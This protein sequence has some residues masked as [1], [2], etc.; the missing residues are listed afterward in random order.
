MAKKKHVPELKVLFDTSVLF[1]QAASDL[2]KPE[3]SQLI[4][5]HSSY[6]DHKISWHL[7]DI[8]RHERR[9]QMLK[10][11]K[12]LLPSLRK[13]EKLLGHNLAIS[14]EILEQRVDAAISAQLDSLKLNIVAINPNNVDWDK[15]MLSAVYRRPPFDPGEREKGFRDALVIESFSQLIATSPVTPTVCRVVLVT[16]DKLLTEAANSAATGS[17]NVRI[18]DTLEELKGF[19]NTLV[20]QVGEEFVAELQKKAQPYFFTQKDKTTLYFKEELSKQIKE[21]YAAELAY[22]PDNVT[23]TEADTWYIGNPSFNKKE[24]QRIFWTS[25]IEPTFKCFITEAKQAFPA[26]TGLIDAGTTTYNSIT[27]LFSLLPEKKA[28]GTF[29]VIFEIDWSVNY[30]PNKKFT[31][32]RIE[33]IRYIETKP[34]AG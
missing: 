8:A 20:S 15:V 11:A 7:P 14:E 33:G 10:A 23:D 19:I 1:T 3:I 29:G 27:G 26:G 22:K 24:G 34:L 4:L 16:G 12:E 6:P 30:G 21:K 32:S 17:S 5:D 13:I 2:V 9:Y 18:L 31:S 25:R 28:A